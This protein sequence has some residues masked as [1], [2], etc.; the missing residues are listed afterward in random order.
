[1]TGSERDR[2]PMDID[3]DPDGDV[4][5][6]AR[7]R[8]VTESIV[9][10]LGPND[11]WNCAALGLLANGGH[12][13][14]ETGNGDGTTAESSSLVTARTWG[15]TRTWR[16]FREEGKGYVQFVRDPVIFTEAALSIREEST[17]ILD[18]ATAW[19]R[20]DVERIDAGESGDTQWVEWALR[21]REKRVHSRVVPT[22]DRGHGAV[23][24]ATVAASR[25]DVPAYDTE[26]LCDRL[27]YFEGVVERCGGPREREAF[28]RLIELVGRQW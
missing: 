26:E 23:I 17:P 4:G 13:N 14:G 25:L 15:R 20:V 27:A 6:P 28:S 22:I 2:E 21:P 16:N 8:G 10:T 11:R 3:G 5:W 19:V 1:M 18:A 7:L 24:E 12:E 9:T